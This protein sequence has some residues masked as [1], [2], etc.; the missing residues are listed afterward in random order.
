MI[1]FLLTR[2]HAYTVGRFL[3]TPWGRE[4]AGEWRVL[5]YERARWKR[6]F[7]PGTY[8]FADVERL[9]PRATRRAAA[10]HDRLSSDPA[11]YRVLNHPALTWRR[12]RLLRT[13]HERGT[14]D[15][16]V[17]RLDDA[18]GRVR[19]PVFL[20]GEN[21]HRGNRT[22]L[23]DGAGQLA[24]A[25]AR[26]RR[27][28]GAPLVT[29][30][31]DTSVGG[32]FRKYAAFRVGPEVIARHLFFGTRWMVKYSDLSGDEYDAE[33]L[34]Y[35]RDNPHRARLAEIFTLARVD[36]G[37]IDYAMLD[38][39]VQVWEINTNPMIASEVSLENAARR[40]AHDLAI[41]RLLSALR[42]LD[43]PELAR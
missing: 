30:F 1:V 20:R 24:E 2:R 36:Y 4:V 29:E 9:G 10:L 3:E 15:F 34:A 18:D 43:G 38:G 12:Y 14:N 23:L 41:G 25:A 31:L 33:E 13:L 40:P 16:T 35:V 11:R 27:V 42:A 37:R 17:H 21:D 22:P 32:V 6:S 28:R 5:A 7:R 39:R 8:I 26:V 19:Y